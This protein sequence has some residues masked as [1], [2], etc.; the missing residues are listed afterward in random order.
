MAHANVSKWREAEVDVSFWLG[1]DS[2]GPNVL[3]LVFRLELVPMPRSVDS[4]NLQPWCQDEEARR[5]PCA[6]SG[7]TEGLGRT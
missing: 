5:L 4:T 2:N 7:P 1:G 6:G 3:T